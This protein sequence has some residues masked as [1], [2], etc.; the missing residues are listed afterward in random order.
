MSDVAPFVDIHC[1][2]LPGIDDGAKDWD[3]TLAM[4]QLAVADGFSTIVVTPHQLGSFAQNRGEQIRAAVVHLQAFLDQHQVPLRVLPGADVRIEVGMLDGLKNGD[5]V[6]L[7]DHRRH[8][9]LELPHELYVPL[10]RLLVDLQSLRMVGVLSHPERNQG[11]QSQ[12]ALVRPLVEAGCLMQLTAGSL[13][14]NF[15]A[16]AQKLSTWMLD[17]GLAHFISTDAHS[18]RSRRPQM[19][20]A[21]A[22]VA[23]R[24]G[25]ETALDL[26]CRNPALVAAGR[27]V[28]GGVRLSKVRS[29][30]S[31]LRWT[32][33]A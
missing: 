33:A 8:V 19:S 18:T 17:Q 5:V 4:A 11:I 26:C 2:L 25:L 20:P 7:G 27:N 14:G 3:E 31:W 24:M 21:F 10:D 29:R 16:A 15:G 1:H 23:E 30:G 22:V 32:K 9:L 6:S 13:T 28:V 12:P